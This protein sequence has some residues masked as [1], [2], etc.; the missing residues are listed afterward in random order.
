MEK[1]NPSLSLEK[2]L[3]YISCLLDAAYNPYEPLHAL[4][5]FNPFV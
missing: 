5:A 4:S 3:L 2:H 1:K